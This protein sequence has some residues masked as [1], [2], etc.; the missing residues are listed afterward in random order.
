MTM[1]KRKKKEEITELTVPQPYQLLN[2]MSSV[3]CRMAN[4]KRLF[5]AGRP[6]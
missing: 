4:G 3:A 1:P 2:V 6:C 5:V